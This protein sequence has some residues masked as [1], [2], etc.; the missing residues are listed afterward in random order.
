MGLRCKK[1]NGMK[2]FFEIVLWI[3]YRNMGNCTHIALLLSKWMKAAL[4]EEGYSILDINMA[5]EIGNIYEGSFVYEED[6]C[7]ISQNFRIIYDGVNIET[8]LLDTEIVESNQK[9]NLVNNSPSKNNNNNN[10][11]YLVLAFL[12]V[13]ILALLGYVI[14]ANKDSKTKEVESTSAIT[15]TSDPNER[16]VQTMDHTTGKETNEE[17][18][19]SNSQNDGDGYDNVLS[20]RKLNEYDLEG[21]TKKELEI[22]RNSIFARY[23][24]RFKR[25][26]LLNY[27]S[28]FSWYYPSTSDMSVASSSM[29]EI[30]IYNV[31]FIKEHE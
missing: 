27:F 21:K 4:K 15:S 30:E 22:M 12:F 20:E 24:Y 2:I 6:G 23:G 16:E 14:W 1:E 8:K 17:I 25:K 29:S 3:V 26:D 13:V 10:I 9:D 11:L 28:Q 18:E 5:Y 19:T 31:N 7:E